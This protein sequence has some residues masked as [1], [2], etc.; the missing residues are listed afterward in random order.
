MKKA[1]AFALAVL[2]CLFLLVSCGQT[3]PATET[4]AA[5][6]QGTQ[7]PT[8]ATEPAET[9]A[10]VEEPDLPDVTF[11]GAEFLFYQWDIERWRIWNDLAVEE[12]NAEPINDAVFRRNLKISEKYDV[13]IRAQTDAY[14]VYQDNVRKSVYADDPL[15]DVCISM[16]HNI[17]HMYQ[18]DLFYDLYD[19]PYLDFSRPWWD[20]NSIE[21]FTM[22]GYLPFAV[23]DLVIL[24]KAASAC[25]YFNKR[26][27][28]DLQLGD[29]YGLVKNGTWTM[30][31]LREMGLAAYVDLNGNGAYDEMDRYGI[32]CGDD[33]VIFFFHAAGGRVLSKDEDGYPALSFKTDRNFEAILYY[34]EKIMYDEKLTFN[35]MY[36]NWTEDYVP[37]FMRD[38]GLFL[39]GL[40]RNS[41]VMREMDSDFGILPIPKYDA[42]QETYSSSASVFGGNLIS[43][44]KTSDRLEMT[45]VLLEALSAESR[46]TVIPAFYETVLKRKIARDEESSAMLDVIIANRVY[47]LGDFLSLNDFSDR[48]LRI[49]GSVRKNNVGG[50][51]TDRTSD[52]ASFYAKYENSLDAEL[53]KLEKI[54]DRWND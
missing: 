6:T 2:H 42:S 48:F 25:V 19:I 24:D 47:D 49:T 15:Y 30:D 38:Q 9:E 45:G 52:I 51:Y 27:A 4:D 35:T 8:E 26:L 11:D 14:D 1:I 29:L 13:T 3:E 36:D 23:S 16:G 53:E 12:E 43:V 10:P 41:N 33:P 22:R 34:L 37:M 46:Y 20:G 21:S 40:L 5:G 44:P 18:N 31:T 39:I 17:A 7:P 54:I 32:L 50:G 28:E